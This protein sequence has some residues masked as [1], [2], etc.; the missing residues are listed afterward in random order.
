[1]LPEIC[2][3]FL[4]I[5]SKKMFMHK[6]TKKSVINPK[7]NSYQNIPSRLTIREILAYINKEVAPFWGY[8]S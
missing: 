5:Q 4:P 2:F 8:L 6:K 1:M 7:Y 3:S